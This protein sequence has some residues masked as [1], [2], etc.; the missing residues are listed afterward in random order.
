MLEVIVGF[1]KTLP[2]WL[3]MVTEALIVAV[4]FS[5]AVIFLWG[6]WVGIKIVGRRANDI[7][8]ITLVP[9]AI[10]FKDHQTD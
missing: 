9:F 4:M 2:T 5:F 10:R 3:H 7:E 8:S 6:M 1:I